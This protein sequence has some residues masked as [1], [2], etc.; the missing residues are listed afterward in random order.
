MARDKKKG[1]HPAEGSET[2]VG[3]DYSEERYRVAWGGGLD[4]VVG[5]E[6]RKTIYSPN[7][8]TFEPDI[9]VHEGYN[10]LWED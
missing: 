4:H 8:T 2:K 7:G 3:P 9:A 5:N 6:E 1:R 10:K